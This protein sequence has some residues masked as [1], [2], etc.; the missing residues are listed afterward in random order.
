MSGSSTTARA[1]RGSRPPWGSPTPPRRLLGSFANEVRR[2]LAD[3]PGVT[4]VDIRL[5]HE[6][7][8][9]PE[10]FAPHDQQRLSA[11]RAAQHARLRR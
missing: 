11:H 1:V 10:W 5:D 7:A 9:T 8:W 6:L 4:G 3:L 2:R